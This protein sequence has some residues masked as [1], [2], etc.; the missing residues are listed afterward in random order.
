MAESDPEDDELAFASVT[1]FNPALHSADGKAFSDAIAIELQRAGSTIS[2]N[3]VLARADAQNCEGC[4]LGDVPIGDG[5]RSPRSLA[6][7]H[8]DESQQTADGVTRF[9]ISP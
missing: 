7:S 2:P 3:D 5:L 8:I 9:A 6:G 1:A 4:H